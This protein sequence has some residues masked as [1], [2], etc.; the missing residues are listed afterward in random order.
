MAELKDRSLPHEASGAPFALNRA[1]PGYLAPIIGRV[2]MRDVIGTAGF[3][4]IRKGDTVT[5]LI[6][7]TAED[8]GKLYEL[9]AATGP[10]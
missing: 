5:P 3:P 2:A 6:A 7:E 4:L 9:V 1:D 10:N 8:M